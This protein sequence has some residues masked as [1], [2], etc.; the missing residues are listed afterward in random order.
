MHLT[1]RNLNRIYN[2][3]LLLGVTVIGIKEVTE[4]EILQYKFK[5]KNP[6]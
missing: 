6:F 3:L 5:R 1:A 4:E 2:R